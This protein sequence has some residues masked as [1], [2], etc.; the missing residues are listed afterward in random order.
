MVLVFALAGSAD[1]DIVFNSLFLTG[2]M[3]VGFQTMYEGLTLHYLSGKMI[4]TVE[5]MLASR[6]AVQNAFFLCV[7]ETL[8]VQQCQLDVHSRP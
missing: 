8:L 3:F 5:H 6:S 7:E 1:S 4:T 2:L